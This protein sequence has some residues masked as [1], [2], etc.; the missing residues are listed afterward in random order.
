MATTTTA[1]L[2]TTSLDIAKSGLVTQAKGELEK[3]MLNGLAGITAGT[4]GTCLSKIILLVFVSLLL[5]THV[6][7]PNHEIAQILIAIS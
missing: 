6:Y 4:V 1:S 2:G 7:I 3:A 5:Y